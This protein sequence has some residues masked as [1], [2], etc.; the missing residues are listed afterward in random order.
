MDSWKR[1]TASH[2]E[3]PD[4]HTEGHWT[5]WTSHMHWNITHITTHNTAVI[6]LLIT[7][8]HSLHLLCGCAYYHMFIIHSSHNNHH[9][10]THTHFICNILYIT[11]LEN[12]IA[13]AIYA[14]NLLH[15]YISAC[16]NNENY[17]C[18]GCGYIS[19]SKVIDV[20]PIIIHS[21]LY[22]VQECHCLGRIMRVLQ[23][24]W[25]VLIYEGQSTRPI[26]VP[27]H[28]FDC[29]DKVADIVYIIWDYETMA[30]WKRVGIPWSAHYNS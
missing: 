28:S 27:S 26:N 7:T 17:K 4:R 8:L 30:Q 22:D 18:S 2:I 13:Q 19:K 25:S 6:T 14:V 10:F 5:H 9:M 24:R 20:V 1:E 11:L 3:D 29:C 21:W 23:N 12:I 15:G 16:N